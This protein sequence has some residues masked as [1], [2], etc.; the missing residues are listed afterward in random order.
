MMRIIFALCLLGCA[1][2]FADVPVNATMTPRNAGHFPLIRDMDVNGGSQ[3]VATNAARDAIPS[4]NRKAGMLVHVTSTQSTYQLQTD[5]VTWA[6]YKP[7][8]CTNPKAAPY[9]AQGD[10]VTDDRA[11]IQ[12]AIDAV[13]L[14]GGGTVCLRAGTYVIGTPNNPS[15]ANVPLVMRSNVALIGESRGSTT[16]KLCD[17]AN[18]ILNGNPLVDSSVASAASL[19]INA[20]NPLYFGAQPQD[21]NISIAHV[22]IE[23]NYN[24]QKRFVYG[25]NASTIPDPTPSATGVDLVGGGSLAA[26]TYTVYTK[27]VDSTGGETG[28]E[29]P[30]QLVF[31]AALNDRLKVFLPP[32]KPVGAASVNLY[33]NGALDPQ[34]HGNQLFERQNF[35]IPPDGLRPAQ[36]FIIVSTH[37]AGRIQLVSSWYNASLGEGIFFDGLDTATIDD[38]AIQHFVLEGLLIGLSDSGPPNSNY[39]IRNS[40]IFSNGRAGAAVNASHTNVV[41]ESD[42]FIA[43]Y[44]GAFDFEPFIATGFGHGL[45]F[46]K[47]A[48]LDHVH[49]QAIAFSPPLTGWV[50]DGFLVSECLF[51]HNYVHIIKG[52]AGTGPADAKIVNNTFKESLNSAV[53]WSMPTGGS[54]LIQGNTFLAA[55]GEWAVYADPPSWSAPDY[56]A[57]SEL[58]WDITTNN[59]TGGVKVIDNHFLAHPLG[60]PV[61]IR[62][63]S[64]TGTVV[65]RNSHDSNGNSN[66]K[67]FISTPNDALT[68]YHI[69][70]LNTTADGIF[71]DVSGTVALAAHATGISI[72]PADTMDTVT[73]TTAMPDANYQVSCRPAWNSGG[74]YVTGKT[75]GGFVLRWPT[76]AGGGG[77]TLDWSAS[78]PQ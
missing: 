30:G 5:L 35:A 54:T 29:G 7:L 47:C 14:A 11:A 41:F 74:C 22:T 46:H 77:S 38:V 73:F 6:P 13:A 25:F 40:T 59:T 21:K 36:P 52:G 71:Q 53:A 18:Q 45:V 23:G 57:N 50:M 27:Y 10:G 63:T 26:D 62:L 76:V 39:L 8:S 64:A 67:L 28:I 65:D 78:Y 60:F 42:D 31:N 75:A 49:A 1:P 61:S 70:A 2:V 3:S 68:N 56:A 9:L 20:A 12:A 37:T 58:I 16:I 48:F 55:N 33:V 69:G 44:S 24:N 72:G 34:D 4:W 19:I 43:N 51:K 66:G 15:N 32:F 17:N